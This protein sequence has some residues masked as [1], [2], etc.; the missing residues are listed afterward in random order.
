MHYIK[1]STFYFFCFI[2]Q[3]ALIFEYS[4]AK[5]NIYNSYVFKFIWTLVNLDEK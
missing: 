1:L 4:Y 2:L 5:I 3:N